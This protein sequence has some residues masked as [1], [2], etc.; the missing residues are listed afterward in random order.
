MA[1]HEQILAEV[2]QLIEQ[3]QL[4]AAREKLQ[5][6]LKADA[7]NPDVWWLYAHAVEDAQSARDALKRV[8][9]LDP[10]YPGAQELLN[11]LAE[12][13]V[14][15]SPQI[16]SLKPESTSQS[17]KVDL[18]DFELDDD[19]WDDEE[20]G[21][22]EEAERA[23]F[24]IG[25]LALITILVV[26]VL[27]L[28]FLLNPSRDGTGETVADLSTPTSNQ[29]AVIPSTEV[30]EESATTSPFTDTLPTPT[31]TTRPVII[32]TETPIPQETITVEST[33]MVDDGVGGGTEAGAD[34]DFIMLARSA[35]NALSIEDV[36]TIDTDIG[37]TTVVTICAG[38]IEEN[39]ENLTAIFGALAEVV[40][41][42]SNVPE[43]I[44]VSLVGCDDAEF[45]PRLIV[46]STADAAEFATGLLDLKAFQSRW[47][48]N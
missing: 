47:R 2:Y 27:G 41:E 23:R 30:T 28:L 42:T 31:S 45:T 22:G 39:N 48:P 37:Q 38:T 21:E 8:V 13:P 17:E 43:G 10:E 19:D 33:E 6:L 40:A 29:V 16:R 3:E 26:V 14:I 5:P 44:G 46:A 7:A 15:P 9:K 4:A 35:L 11:S 12:S 36:A 1:S 32:S 20:E 18:S 25:F 24:P 34:D